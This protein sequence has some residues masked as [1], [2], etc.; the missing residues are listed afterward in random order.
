MD[1]IER[2]FIDGWDVETSGLPARVV[3]CCKREACNTVGDL[4]SMNHSDLMNWRSLGANSIKAIEVFFGLCESLEKGGAHPG[5]FE[6]LLEMFL[7][8]AEL[9]VLI[10]RYGLDLRQVAPKRHINTLQHIADDRSLTRERVRQI[11][12]L[13]MNKLSSRIAT[14]FLLPFTSQVRRIIED[15]AGIMSYET[16]AEIGIDCL[17]GLNN[18]AALLLMSDINGA[19]FVYHNGFFSTWKS[20]DIDFFAKDTVSKLENFDR[21]VRAEDIS[22]KYGLN[23]VMNAVRGNTNLLITKDKHLIFSDLSFLC[24]VSGLLPDGRKKF[25]YRELKSWADEVLD[26][27]TRKGSGYYLRRLLSSGCFNKEGFGTYSIPK[28]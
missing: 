10:A 17:K 9:N 1:L 3:N 19:G 22:S 8:E 18:C 7:N 27:S 2:R 13:A 25:H 14:C 5:S 16:A 6:S 26:Q 24:F 21:P 11:Q 23:E 20:A 4:R 15:H 12:D 28:S